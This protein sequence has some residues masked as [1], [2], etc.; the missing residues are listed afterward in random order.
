M[1]RRQ[2][3]Q[4]SI[5]GTATLAGVTAAG[6]AQGQSGGVGSREVYEWRT[7]QL[8]DESKQDRVHEYLKT[9]AVP[10]WRRL[11]LG[12]IG[13]FTEVGPDAGP[14]IHVLLTYPDAA[15]AATARE[16]LEQDSQYQQA[17]AEYLQA[18]KEDPAFAR[19]DSWL[20]LA[21]KGAPQL[22]PPK[23]KTRILEL[24]TY[25]S[26]SEDRARAKVDM[27]NDGEIGIFPE[28]GFENVF[29]GEALVG[30]GLPCLKY[31]LA[32]PS[33]E[34]NAE[35]WQTFLANETF[36]KMKDDPKYADT[37]SKITKLFLAPTEYSQV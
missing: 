16:R 19:I 4:T 12:P 21:F 15:A 11:G 13:A 9:A 8:D 26:F 31:M 5:G 29:F 25:E 22:T 33:L 30:Q 27:F 14:S 10:G 18:K 37:V 2:F 7:Y 24:R 23:P 32:S 20:L 17:A 6:L 28:C 34:K 36:V 3:I 35:S 1:Q